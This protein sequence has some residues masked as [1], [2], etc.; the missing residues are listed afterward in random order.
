MIS[1]P[2]QPIYTDA[3]LCDEEI[4]GEVENF[5]DAILG[6]VEPE[7]MPAG[8]ELVLDLSDAEDPHESTCFY[9]FVNSSNRTLFWF[10]PLD[11]RPLLNGLF[12]VKSKRRIRKSK[13]L[14]SM[15]DPISD[16]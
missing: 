15:F 1:L 6:K 13:F 9:Y 5:R 11:L 16:H 2:S 8:W 3:Y 4:R 10:H 14:A 7:R 12:H